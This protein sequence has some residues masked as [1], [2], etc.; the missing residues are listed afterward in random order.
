MYYGRHLGETDVLSH[1][2]TPL[3]EDN[4][5]AQVGKKVPVKPTPIIKSSFV[6]PQPNR[7][8]TQP[9]KY[10]DM[11]VLTGF[12]YFS[13]SKTAI[14]NPRVTS[15][16]KDLFTQP[17]YI[18]AYSLD[19][20][21]ISILTSRMP[22][23][24]NQNLGIGIGK[25]LSGL[26]DDTTDPKEFIAFNSLDRP[27]D[28][29]GTYHEGRAVDIFYRMRALQ[30]AWDQGLVSYAMI[31]P[32]LYE[33][34]NELPLTVGRIAAT[35]SKAAG[36]V[37]P[38]LGAAMQEGFLTDQPGNKWRPLN[39]PSP[40]IRVPIIMPKPNKSK[41]LV[42]QAINV[43]SK[44][45]AAIVTGGLTLV[46]KSGVL[47][48]DA[49]K[50][51]E[52]AETVIAGGTGGA[53]TGFVASGFNPVGLVAGAGAGGAKGLVDAT[54]K[55]GANKDVSN[56]FLQ[57][58]AYGAAAGAVTG[59]AHL[60]AAHPFITASAAA[61][62]A[63]K[64]AGAGA[65]STAVPQLTT[66]QIMPPVS[67][68]VPDLLPGQTIVGPVDVTDPAG[69]TGGNVSLFSNAANLATKG[70]SALKTGKGYFD[71]YKG[72]YDD[73]KTLIGGGSDGSQPIAP[74]LGAPA[75]SP[76]VAA[77]KSPVVLYASIGILGLLLFSRVKKR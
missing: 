35:G 55:G 66:G 75:P 76:V 64:A 33:L 3:A 65:V 9:K 23:S 69:T 52:K 42:K 73:V 12:N 58:A 61:P 17:G 13:R 62:V 74:T 36:V 19:K 26:A 5:L 63:A 60:I 56:T 67:T 18:P 15:Y 7:F 2:F 31:Q 48:E 22:A 47:G 10:T 68:A 4:G 50:V 53:V 11:D 41:N 24:I 25:G 45:T 46:G 1:P 43:G 32:T 77:V 51:A 27:L 38:I 34:A 21:N 70:A 30:D 40:P 49:K 20:S 44:A 59:A 71:Q 39:P 37:N 57:G 29:S 28:D 14:H 72:T 8:V 16:E 6:I 54:K